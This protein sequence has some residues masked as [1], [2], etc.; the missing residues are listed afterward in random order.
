M[1]SVD[2][3]VGITNVRTFKIANTRHL[4]HIAKI[5]AY[6]FSHSILHYLDRKS[7]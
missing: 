3:H 6:K 4:G 1:L 7:H 5:I 2:F